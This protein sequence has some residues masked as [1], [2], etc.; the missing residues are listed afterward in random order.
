[1]LTVRNWPRAFYMY[2]VLGTLMAKTAHGY[3][4]ATTSS[5]RGTVAMLREDT[6]QHLDSPIGQTAQEAR[7]STP[8][9]AT[10]GS[11][12]MVRPT[13]SAT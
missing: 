9:F 4:K 6:R 8:D 3:D 10:S 13:V 11:I 2:E 5:L 7:T 1:M 12:G